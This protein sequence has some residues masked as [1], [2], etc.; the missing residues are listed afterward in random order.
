MPDHDAIG[1][2]RL[3][4]GDSLWAEKA[5]KTGKLALTFQHKTD[6]GAFARRF[7][8]ARTL[9]REPMICRGKLMHYP[10]Q[11]KPEVS[12]SISVRKS[13]PPVPFRRSA[14]RALEW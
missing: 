10:Q 4:G 2:Q 13:W 7:A 1:R 6:D 11:M 8:P 3:D 14:G 12:A 5:L 9:A